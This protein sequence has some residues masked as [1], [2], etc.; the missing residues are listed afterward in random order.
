METAELAHEKLQ[1]LSKKFAAIYG[2]VFRMHEDLRLKGNVPPGHGW[3]HDI[4]VAQF[5]VII[6]KDERVGELAWIAGLLHST[7]RIKSKAC[8]VGKSVAELLLLGADQ[9]NTDEISIITEAVLEHGGKN[10]ESDSPVTRALKDADRLANLSAT[11]IIRKG[12]FFVGKPTCLLDS[13]DKQ[14]PEGNY[15]KPK[16]GLDDIYYMMEWWEE[17]WF[18]HPKAIE[19][20]RPRYAFLRNYTLIIQTQAAELGLTPFTAPT[21]S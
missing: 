14:H 11:T 18:R 3:D 4:M 15:K 19:L 16:S 5:G 12:Q 2:A 9:L 1:R 6:A 21:A 7:D 13:L 10:K 20:A 8:D 17:S